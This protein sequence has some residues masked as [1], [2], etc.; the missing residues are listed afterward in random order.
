MELWRLEKLETGAIEQVRAEAAVEVAR[1]QTELEQV[2]AQVRAQGSAQ[3]EYVEAMDAAAENVQEHQVALAVLETR[4][5]AL[6]AEVERVTAERREEGQ[7]VRDGLVAKHA[8]EQRVWE[9]EVGA[10]RDELEGV[11][12]H[13]EQE[14][15]RFAQQRHDAAAE[16]AVA[17]ATATAAT[18][19]CA[20]L[21]AELSR[22]H[23]RAHEKHAHHEEKL[24]VAQLSAEAEMQRTVVLENSKSQ[25]AVAELRLTFS[26]ERRK[27]KEEIIGIANNLTTL[28]AERAEAKKENSFLLRKVLQ[29]ESENERERSEHEEQVV[30]LLKAIGIYDPA[31][32]DPRNRQEDHANITWAELCRKQLDEERIRIGV[33][34]AVLMRFSPRLTRE[35]NHALLRAGIILVAG[36]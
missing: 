32:Y 33:L 22:A 13:H 29:L 16:L 26:E 24:G 1:L 18:T 21:R 19:Q 20:E 5:E 23:E 10:L 8:G 12:T 4:N 14:V 7:R 25:I 31:K 15:M 2:R 36:L 30:S 34:K 3:A 11:R 27:L 17:V 35:D 28:E 9:Q 6:A